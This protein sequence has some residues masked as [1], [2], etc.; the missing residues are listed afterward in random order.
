MSRIEE[1][2]R[3]CTAA[4]AGL[5]IPVLVVSLAVP[6]A[7][8][9][10]CADLATLP[11]VNT[12]EQTDT[13]CR[14]SLTLRPSSDSEIGS[15]VR[16]PPAALWNGKLLMVGGG[17]FVGSVNAGG[18]ARAVREGYAAASTDGGHAGGSGSFALGHPEK[19]VDF[20]YRAVHET[21]VRA[22]ALIADHYGQGPRLSYWHGCSTGGRQGLMSA[23]R[24]PDDFDG[25]L[26]GAPANNQIYLCA[27]RMRLLMTALKSPRHA[28]SAGNLKL[29]ND[30]VLEQCDAADGVVDRLIE[31]PGDCEFVLDS[32]RCSGPAAKGCL[33]V[34]QME[35]VSAAYSDLRTS[36]GELLYPG[37]PVG[38]ELS[39]TLPPDDQ[40]PGAM[41][42]DMFRYIANQ[43]ASW[44]WRDFDLEAD[45]ERALRHGEVIH[46]VDPDLAAF[47]ARGGKLLLYHGWSDGGSGGAVS[48][49][50]TIAYYESV[51]K[52]MGADQ[53][54]WIRL[55]L[56]PG[57]AHCGGGTGP[58]QFH[59][60][61]ALERW[62]ER[63]QPPAS[64][65]AGRVNEHGAIDMTRPLCPYPQQAVYQG[66]GSTND[67]ENFACELKSGAK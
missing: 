64:I 44:N 62:R 38:G 7:A 50:N 6:L 23:Q 53:D 30:A 42:I 8:R 26:A 9:T 19:V 36:S 33:T 28:L 41:D 24:Y 34:Q 39:W 21:V 14:L 52:Q 56:V 58:N 18:M 37:L 31:N 40:E 3:S 65:T 11:D 35:T 45:V 12:A 60:L 55:F 49:F 27:W 29:L 17:G 61:A 51:L 5:A 32:L 57:M 54:D 16:M 67:A 10:P 13:D 25:I 43:D 46:A 1:Y 2:G 22:K 20:A 15:E 66:T 4:F 47:K 63:D 48:A 59:V